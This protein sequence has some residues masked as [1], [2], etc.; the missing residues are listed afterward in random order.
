MNLCNVYVH[1]YDKLKCSLSWSF[2]QFK[3]N[4]QILFE[5]Y[6]YSPNYPSHIHP[7]TPPK[8]ICQQFT[9]FFFAI[10]YAFFNDNTIASFY[11]HCTLVLGMVSCWSCQGLFLESPTKYIFNFGLRLGL[12]QT[13]IIWLSLSMICYLFYGVCIHQG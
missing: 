8:K 12:H 5:I 1:F 2:D 10:A 13:D 7:P 4:T 3:L 11:V 6:V 9:C